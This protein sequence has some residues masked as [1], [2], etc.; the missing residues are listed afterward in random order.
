M[1]KV[2]ALVLF[3]SNLLFCVNSFAADEKEKVNLGEIVVTASGK[4]ESSFNFPGNVSVI[5]DKAIERSNALFAYD[6]LRSEPGVYV[7]D[8]THTG[9]SVTVDIRGF[10]DTAARNVL[11]MMDGRRLNEIDISG[12]DWA[13]IPV[14]NIERIEV[15]RGSGSVMYGENATGGVVN[16]ITKKG[17]G[18]S[19]LGYAYET[20]SYRLNKQVVTAQGGHPFMQ[21]NLLGKYEKTD[22]YRVNG[23][24]E[25]YDYD[26]NTTFKPTEYASLNV[27][28]GYHKDWYG[29]PAGLRRTQMDQ[30]GRNGSRTPYDWAKTETGYIQLSPRL[31]LNTGI[32]TNSLEAD[33]WI[34]KMRKKSVTNADWGVPFGMVI[35]TQAS[36]IANDGGTF[37]Y[38]IGQNY[39]S[40]N[41]EAILGVDLFF[42]ENWLMSVTP[43]VA[44][45]DQLTI[46]KKNIGV[47]GSDKLTIADNLII[48][49]GYRY[50]WVNY[51]FDQQDDINNYIERTPSESSVEIGA[52]YK[53]AN[54]G[55]IYGRFSTSYRFPSVDEFYSIFTG[56]TPNL[57]QQASETWEVGIKEDTLKYFTA[58]CGFFLMN[59]HNEIYYDPTAG[60]G[61]GD[62][63]NYD[64]TQRK[65]VELSLKSDM[66]EYLQ[67]YFNYTYLNAYFLDGAFA[68]NKV[69]MVPASK[70]NWGVI[71]TP[72]VFLD[73]HFWSDYTGIQYPINDQFNRQPKLKDYFVCNI[74]A[75]FKCKG[76][77]VFAGVNN[78]FNQKYSELASASVNGVNLDYFPAPQTNWRF[79]AS[80]KF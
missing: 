51:V 64:R 1:K 22:G 45:F 50:E 20:G 12:P 69:P 68:G 19:T 5:T 40:I 23:Y 37:R 11:V 60:G 33:I 48:N 70:V 10:G 58:K 62:N 67:T 59:T 57:K 34:R 29:M 54:R 53:Y 25:G 24:F 35:S 49:G 56:L 47:Y 73:V 66:S 43:A 14:E 65:G 42:A 31:D 55:A 72:F 30:V 17:K 44:S 4:E 76:W 27:S 7:V 46:T 6:L 74:K 39:G 3:V 15:M 9:K 61:F 52:E 75:T 71:W 38:R 63:G 28:G 79:G 41:N 2:L 36:Q 78:I 32:D 21:Y 16:I 13:Q 18:D 8:Q 80:C 26:G 77:E